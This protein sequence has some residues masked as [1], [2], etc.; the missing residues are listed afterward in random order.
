MKKLVLAGLMFGSVAMAQNSYDLLPYA[1][2]IDYSGTT[3][4]DYGYVGG[5]YFS[6]LESPWKIEL[7]AEHTDIKYQDQ[8]DL[9]QSDF[10][11][12]LNYYEGYNLAYNMGLHYID[13]TDTLTDKGLIYMG[14]ISY[15][16]TLKYNVGMDIYYS[17]YS[18]LSTSPTIF[19]FSPKAGINFGNY[20]SK[21][22]SF[23]TEAKLDYIKPSK[24]KSENYLKSS[25]TS[26]EVT[27]N[28]YNGKFTTS[29]NGW[30]G[31][32]AYAIENGGFIVNNLSNEQTGGFKISENYK[33]DSAQSVK[34][35]YS[36][37]KFKELGDASSDTI[38][39]SYNYAF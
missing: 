7:D 28:N 22:G 15:Y 32:R 8:D 35:E 18:N 16:Q 29:I 21:I 4:K 25:Y 30:A 33:L 13:T 39:A 20:N 26:I 24:N 11:A 5:I 38:L 10:T 17:D 2:Y 14:G 6:S 27:L 31:K 23:Y 1:G 3:T 37:T 12:K 9:K 34:M 19:Q 36:Y